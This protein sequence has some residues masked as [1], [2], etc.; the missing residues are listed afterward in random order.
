MNFQG[1]GTKVWEASKPGLR[2]VAK[3]ILAD[4][5]VPMLVDPL[6]DKVAALIPGTVDDVAINAFK[7]KL[8]E[9]LLGLADKI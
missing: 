2:L 3:G 5:A 1:V 4:V 8:K 7:P 9:I 6:L